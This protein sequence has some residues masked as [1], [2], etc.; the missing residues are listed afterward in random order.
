MADELGEVG[1]A[2]IRYQC[3]SRHLRAANTRLLAEPLVFTIHIYAH[4]TAAGCVVEDM[5]VLRG[6]EP[7]HV[8]STMRGR[9]VFFMMNVHCALWLGM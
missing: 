4:I 7:L 1:A 2:T 8:G 6:L 9:P 5:R 3:R